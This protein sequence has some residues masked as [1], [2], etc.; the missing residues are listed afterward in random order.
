[1]SPIHTLRRTIRRGYFK[2][3]RLLF[4]SGESK[5]KIALGAAYGVFWGLTPTVGLQSTILILKF[6]FGMFLSR[7]SK[8]KF[9]HLEF[10]FPLALALTWISNPFDA[11]FLYFAFYYIGAL[12]M[13]GYS[14]LGF[15]EFL[16]LLAPLLNVDGLL[17]SISELPTYLSNIWTMVKDLGVKVVYPLIIGSL[18]LA[19][20]FGT[21]SYFW[22][23]RLIDRFEKKK[24]PP[25]RTITQSV[26]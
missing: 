7:I 20:P 25:T 16:T 1:M 4:Y 26:G 6:T 14:P 9:K 18:V 10:N 15:D 8:G 19:I 11:P 23:L 21:A 13:P 12:V 24:G 2:L 5:H 17:G 22:C 3:L